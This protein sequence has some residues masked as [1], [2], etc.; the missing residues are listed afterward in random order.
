MPSRPRPARPTCAPSRWAD[1][2]LLRHRAH[3][4]QLRGVIRAA[5]G[6]QPHRP[7]P[8]L[9]RV[10]P[11]ASCQDSILLK[12][13]SFPDSPGRFTAPPRTAPSALQAVSPSPFWSRRP[14]APSPPT[15]SGSQA[16]EGAA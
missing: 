10:L 7:L 8:Q 1:A 15:G 14:N 5:P 6:D 2:R 4:L 12:D 3:R 16:F 11:V 13:W 9:R